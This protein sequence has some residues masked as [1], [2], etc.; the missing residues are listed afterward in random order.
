[1]KIE[2]TMMISVGC[3]DWNSPKMIFV[4]TDGKYGKRL[5]EVAKEAFEKYKATQE[6]K[7]I[8]MF[9]YSWFGDIE[10]LTDKK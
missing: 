4:S 6:N 2:R 7:D 10:I 3:R 8:Y 5:E 1:M 9:D